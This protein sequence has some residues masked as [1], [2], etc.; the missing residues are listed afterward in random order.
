MSAENL[1]LQGYFHED[2]PSENLARPRETFHQ[3]WAM[4]E[5]IVRNDGRNA[6][7]R[8]ALQD[9]RAFEFLR[10]KNAQLVE[11]IG[12]DFFTLKDADERRTLVKAMLVK[13]LLTELAMRT[14]ATRHYMGEALSDHL[15][16]PADWTRTPESVQL[17]IGI[18]SKETE[19]LRFGVVKALQALGTQVEREAPARDIEAA[20]RGLW[21]AIWDEV[22]GTDTDFQILYAHSLYDHLP[23]ATREL[24]ETLAAVAGKD[25]ALDAWLHP[26]TWLHADKDGRP[27]DTN[28]HTARL[29]L[30]MEDAVRGRYREDLAAL[31]ATHPGDAPLSEALRR[32]DRA[33]PDAFEEPEQ[34]LRLIATSRA[35]GDARLDDL[36]LRIKTFGFFFAKLEYRENAG[37]FDSVL[38][39]ILPPEIIGATLGRAP[40]RYAELDTHEKVQLLT[41]LQREGSAH[42]PLAIWQAYWRKTEAEFEARRQRHPNG[43][44]LELLKT[45]PAYIRMLDAKTMVE[46]FEMI[47]DGVERMPIHGIAES[48][49]I[50]GPLAVLFFMEAAGL[51]NGIDVALQPEDIEGAETTLAHI[52]ELYENPVY[53]AHLQLRG[54]KQYI[55]FGPSDTGKQGG[56][57]MHKANMRIANL[58]KAI[59]KEHG[60][61]AVL[62]VILGYE[63]ARCNG[64]IAEAMREYSALESQETRFMMAGCAEMRSHLLTPERAVHCLKGLFAMHLDAPRQDASLAEIER[65]RGFWTSVVRQYQKIFFEHPALPN[66]LKALARFDVVGATAKGT[67][68]PSRIFNIENFESRPDA[69]RAIPWTRALL[70]G[71]IHS[72]LIGAGVLA[73]E[74]AVRLAAKFRSNPSFSAYVKNIA[75]ALARTDMDCAWLTVLGELPSR[76]VVE[77]WAAELNESAAEPAH[78]MLASLHLEVV[79]AKRFVYKALHGHEPYDDAWSL[80]AITLLARWPGLQ[81]E[82]AWKEDNLRIYRLLLPYLRRDPAFLRSD[83]VH[84]F[85]SGL[86]AAANTDTGIV[87]PRAVDAMGWH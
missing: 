8:R 74:P 66:L 69:I 58:H 45:D 29:V 40:R 57:A 20:L 84:D 19:Q 61:E 15:P 86:L 87:H 35:R 42:R 14:S 17:N 25:V 9:I 11:Q 72:E 79:R 55:T 73:D 7:C 46:R 22:D 32:L 21:D 1:Q 48:D 2:F 41:D 71:G 59:A 67:R 62:H 37:M 47:R 54:A 52:R 36:V 51:R 56:K 13:Q 76:E 4:F 68:P 82:V 78:R 12:R 49:G 77:R 44:Y 64:P 3:L 16:T 34:L 23:R 60:V 81:Q 75:Y 65:E 83:A 31:L 85:Y 50:D 70:V 28:A 38:D 53:K 18:L 39:E 6:H 63:H 10:G 5:E 30:A 43:D 27:Y 80:A 26:F 24:R 33:E